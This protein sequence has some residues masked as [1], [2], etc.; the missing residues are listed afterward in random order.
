MSGPA[1]PV[2]Y[3]HCKD[4]KRWTGAA[5][6]AF[7]TFDPTVVRWHPSEPEPFV[8][9]TG[10]QRWTCQT[11]GSAMAARFDYLPD[12]VYVPLGVI[13]QIERLAPTLHCHAESRL[14]WLDESCKLPEHSGS[15]R[16]ALMRGQD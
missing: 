5:A 8:T 14:A 2:C 12:Q 10:V 6:P 13:D 1:D 11:C 3:C 15:G 4:C 9:T 16:D 7:A